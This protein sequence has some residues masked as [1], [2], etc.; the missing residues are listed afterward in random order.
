MNPAGYLR[1]LRRRWLDV[2]LAVVVAL[3]AG[4]A[5]TAVAPAGPATVTYEATSV[6]IGTGSPYVPGLGNLR[7]LAALTTVGEVPTRVAERLDYEGDPLDLARAVT[8]EVD[9]E[10]GILTITA[11][12]QDRG[13]AARLA[14]GFARELMTFV[15]DKQAEGLALDTA[16]VTRRLEEL[17]RLIQELDDQI[18][19]ASGSELQLLR[20][21]RDAA[22]RQYGVQYEAYQSIAYSTTEGTNLDLVQT[23]V[24]VET[25][26]GGLQAPRSR[27]SRLALAGMLG[28]ISGVVIVLFLDRYDVRIR[29]REDGERHFRLPVLA[30][31]PY[32]PRGQ[33]RRLGLA[34]LTA[35]RSR[36][37]DAFRMV[38][39]MLS[40]PGARRSTGWMEVGE[41]GNGLGRANG[42]GEA[43]VEV[44]GGDTP[45]VILV[46]SPG[47]ADG[48]TTIVANLAVAF[49]AR[50]NRVL[51]L[52]CDLRRPRIHRVFGLSNERGVSDLLAD[53]RPAI[54]EAP[55]KTKV[56]RLR[57]VPSGPV[58]EEPS[59]LLA[60]PAMEILL[61]QARE[62]AD[63]VLID[64][65][66]LLT[67]SDAIAML[68][69]VDAVVVVARAGRT[70]VPVAVRASELLRRLEAP[71][72]GLVL[73]AAAEIAVPGRYYGYYGYHGR[74][75]KP[76]R[77]GFPRLVRQST[78]T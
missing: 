13:M 72:I 35:P 66:P 11:L 48:K 45:R 49:A 32:V 30:E 33:R 40:M 41:E 68:P 60:S 22:V 63:V 78:K 1:A 54:G 19:S 7:S 24:P 71:V 5:V 3:L 20:A 47:P 28:L 27:A 8:V 6:I 50:G 75:S 51:I 16:V 9:A 31:I 53:E 14:D 42:K 37:A 76:A 73:N 21:Q 64:T 46:T 39:T 34:T 43:V 15:R 70:S 58:P 18:A 56:E 57:V 4:L 74:S 10:A 69:L 67:T 2:V 23:A 12:S 77:R 38:A 62:R 29:T 61:R 65:A 55:E 36:T 44:E 52:D 26:A 25:S 17:E 59:E